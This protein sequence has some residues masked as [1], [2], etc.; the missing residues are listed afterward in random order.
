MENDRNL[1]GISM[2][3]LTPATPRFVDRQGALSATPGLAMGG[4]R[5][6]PAYFREVAR[7]SVM[8]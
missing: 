3:P 4:V 5:H 1:V 7:E 6:S 8:A 2:R